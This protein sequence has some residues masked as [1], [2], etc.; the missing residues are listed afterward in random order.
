MKQK[1]YLN[2]MNENKFLRDKEN[3]IRKK[4]EEKRQ[5]KIQAVSV[6]YALQK[7]INLEPAIKIILELLFGIKARCLQQISNY[8]KKQLSHKFAGYNDP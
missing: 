8:V 7:H 2:S 3:H 4:K 6:A 5:Q 1:K